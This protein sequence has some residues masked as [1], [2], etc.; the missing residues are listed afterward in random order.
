MPEKDPTTW[1]LAT[2]ALIIGM[3]VIGGV[4]RF[5]CVIRDE[6]IKSVS[7]LGFIADLAAS[8]LVGIA[9][10]MAMVS[11]DYPLALCAAAAGMSG[12]MATR[13]LFITFGLADKLGLALEDRILKSTRKPDD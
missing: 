8:G 2:W 11:F 3:S 7:I 1:S 9:A 10:F 6:G 5:L 13:I 12:H 4:S